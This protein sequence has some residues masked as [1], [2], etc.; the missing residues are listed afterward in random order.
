MPA[1]QQA[2]VRPAFVTFI[3]WLFSIHFFRTMSAKPKYT[4]HTAFISKTTYQA[5]EGEEKELAD[6][7]NITVV[8]N[9]SDTYKV[10]VFNVESSIHTFPIVPDSAT[11]EPG[12]QKPTGGMWTP[13]CDNRQA[14]EEG[15]YI[16]ITLS[17]WGEDDHIYQLFQWGWNVY[18]T[19]NMDYSLR[20]HIEGDYNVKKGRVQADRLWIKR[21]RRQVHIW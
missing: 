8:Q 16:R 2:C 17:K 6:V 13:C 4:K 11:C 1:F 9:D 19:V 7:C 5:A 15:H 18:K 3:N 10:K 12:E 21:R 20:T 14:L